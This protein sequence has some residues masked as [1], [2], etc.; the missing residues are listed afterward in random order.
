MDPLISF[1]HRRTIGRWCTTF[2]H[3][4]IHFVIPLFGYPFFD[5]FFFSSPSEQ[6]SYRYLR[7][8]SHLFSAHLMRH[9]YQLI[10]HRIALFVV[11]HG[12]D[13]QHILRT[14]LFSFTR[15]T[16]GRGGSWIPLGIDGLIP[17]YAY[18]CSLHV[19]RKEMTRR[20]E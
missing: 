1:V 18:H 17:C 12:N 16:G 20:L 13:P 6:S 8:S 4:L 15:T 19:D 3:F 11:H 2:T 10:I 5:T 14:F 7:I 9:L